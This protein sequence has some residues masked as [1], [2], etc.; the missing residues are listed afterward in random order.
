MSNTDSTKNRIQNIYNIYKPVRIDEKY[1]NAQCINNVRHVMIVIGY[2]CNW[3]MHSLINIQFVIDY[4][5]IVYL[6]IG[7][8]N[9][10]LMINSISIDQYTLFYINC[11]LTFI[12]ESN[13]F[14]YKFWNFAAFFITRDKAS[15]IYNNNVRIF[16]I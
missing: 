11:N 4:N 2:D 6:L 14:Y 8:Y 3:N 15:N 13:G 9:I 1:K 12:N 7:T 5:W 10:I 16:K